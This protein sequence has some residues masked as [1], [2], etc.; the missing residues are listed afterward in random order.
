MVTF[1]PS[2]KMADGVVLQMTVAGLGV[3]KKEPSS[4][5]FLLELS[6]CC[7]ILPK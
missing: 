1:L 7:E 4:R 5:Y 6:V 3:F 2:L